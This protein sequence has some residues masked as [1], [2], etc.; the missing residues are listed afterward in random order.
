MAPWQGL[1]RA[2]SHAR[3]EE[4]SRGAVGEPSQR[5]RKAHLGLEAWR[6]G[7][8]E[9]AEP[10]GL[11]QA[12][13]EPPVRGPPGNRTGGS[14]SPRG[15]APLPASGG[16]V[17]DL[18]GRR[19]G[20]ER[21][22]L[23]RVA[24]TPQ[25][26]A[27]PSLAGSPQSTCSWPLS[28]WSQG[29]TRRGAAREEAE[30][31]AAGPFGRQVSAAT[32]T[33]ASSKEACEEPPL[34]GPLAQAP[35]RGAHPGAAPDPQAQA[36][37][38]IC[39]LRRE[40]MIP[41]ETMQAAMRLF[42]EHATVPADG[43]LFTD[44]F[45]PRESLEG[46]MKQLAGSDS[47]FS[48]LAGRDKGGCVN[49]REFAIWFSSHSFDEPVVLDASKLELRQLSRELNMSA[50]EVET[51]KRHFDSF[52]TDGN[53]RIDRHEFYEMIVK[54]L[55]VPKHIGLPAGRLQQLW[56]AADSDGSGVINFAEFAVFFSKYFPDAGSCGMSQYYSQNGLLNRLHGPRNAW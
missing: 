40:T 2:L 20:K 43:V 30:D 6:S 24:S 38:E 56:A 23:P 21:A 16:P 49:F 42:R 25:Q 8:P 46:V 10:W 1:R 55:K 39:R 5:G 34:A 4:W 22:A 3:P 32:S 41:L 18:L 37:K 51:Y 35:A 17:L 31:C 19:R 52:D 9:E 28:T 11:A 53:G 29:S 44:G 50:S 12:R 13:G 27:A 36:V 26:P 54:C 15:G 47:A 7:A 33:A 48:R 45:L 14:A